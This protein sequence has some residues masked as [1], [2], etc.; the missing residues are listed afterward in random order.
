MHRLTKNDLRYNLSKNDVLYFHHIPKTAGTSFIFILQ[1]YFNSDSILKA[2][3]WN[4]LSKNFPKDFSKFQ[5]VKGHFGNALHQILQKKIVYIT[6]LRN[7][8]DV[9][10]SYLN[11]VKRWPVGKERWSI[12]EKDTISDLILRQDIPGVKNPQCLWLN[13]NLDVKSL[14]KGFNPSIPRNRG[15]RRSDGRPRP[16][17]P[18]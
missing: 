14:T 1:N 15:R 9:I 13:F 16:Q 11:Q 12:S 3:S 5:L 4:R 6:M 17:P 10:I 18:P 2:Q 7:P 8:S